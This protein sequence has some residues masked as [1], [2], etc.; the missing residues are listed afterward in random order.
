MAKRAN[1]FLVGLVSLY[2]SLDGRIRRSEYWLGGLALNVLQAMLKFVVMALV[3]YTSTTAKVAS[4]VIGCVFL[5]PS[6]ALMVKR[7]H[8]RG[9]PAWISFALLASFLAAGLF[10]E[11]VKILYG[12]VAVAIFVVPVF[13]VGLFFVIEYAFM[14]GDPGRNMFGLSPKNP[15]GGRPLSFDDDALPGGNA[16]A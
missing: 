6:I 2:I 5:W 14:D 13:L 11:P 12:D 4:F 1:T 15:D 16:S 7:G 9:R 10:A 8:D 3:G